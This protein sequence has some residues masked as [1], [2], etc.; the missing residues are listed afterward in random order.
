MA[1]ASVFCIVW[2]R[3]FVP[4]APPIANQVDAVSRSIDQRFNCP[5]STAS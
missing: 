2:A 3:R 1:L 5:T 4:F